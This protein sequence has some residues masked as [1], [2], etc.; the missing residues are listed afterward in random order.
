MKNSRLWPVSMGMMGVSLI[1]QIYNA[2]VPL[3]LQAG[4]IDFKEG[5]GLHGFALG[6]ATTG[7]VMTLDN[8]A[9][10]LILPFVGMLSDKWG[11][12]K[13]FIVVGAPLAALGM[14]LVPFAN[15]SLPLFIAALALV[16]LAMDMF[17]TPLTA[18]LA[19]LT[20]PEKRS[21][22]NGRLML[23]YGLGSVIAFAAGGALFKISPAAPFLLA[24][25]GMFVAGLI[26]AFFV[27][28]R[29][30]GAWESHAAQD[31]ATPGTLAAIADSLR[32]I[33]VPLRRL[34]AATFL[35]TLGVSAIEIFFTSFAVKQ[36]ALDGGKAMQLM[37]FFGIAG[38]VGAIP[39]GFIGT[40]FGRK[41]AICAGLSALI[42]IMPI[43][44]FAPS[45]LLLRVLLVG[46]GLS[47]SLVQV[48]ALPYALDYAPERQEG[49]FTGLFLLA[50]QLASVV[51]PILSGWV[52]SAA[53][54]DYRSVFVYVP[55]CMAFALAA[56]TLQKASS[57]VAVVTPRAAPAE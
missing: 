48:N 53:G 20:P 14:A 18:L 25:G 41:T 30:T 49:T 23:G 32:R 43:I 35:W 6:T 22:G 16:I 5:A 31:A 47:W 27:P 52:V 50:G 17:R 24:A 36:F 4:R 56:L 40:R 26:V 39:A 12:R 55:V 38:I 46:M 3:F 8:L 34:I 9:A 21:Q 15:A 19:D 51:G 54:N 33:S 11:N 2:Y 7:F 42:V 28:E 10:L 29:R 44:A 37:G 1:W 45:L 57:R 13:A